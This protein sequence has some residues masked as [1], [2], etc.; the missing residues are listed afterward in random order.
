MEKVKSYNL[1]FAWVDVWFDNGKY[2][3]E[4]YIVKRNGAGRSA[5]ATAEELILLI[6]LLNRAKQDY[7]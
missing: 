3:F 5:K 7:S 2:L 6:E 1:G 4:P